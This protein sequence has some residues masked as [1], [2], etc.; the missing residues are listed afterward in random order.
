MQE[1]KD[2]LQARDIHKDFSGL[3]VL[4]GV[5]FEVKQNEKHAIIGPNGA[6]KTTLFN[7]ISGKYKP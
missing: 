5:D 3:K 6:G 7:I 1:P 2:I 4:T